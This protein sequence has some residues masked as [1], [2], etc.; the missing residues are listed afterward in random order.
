VPERL[1]Y[2]ISLFQSCGRIALYDDE[3][4]EE[5][6]WVMFFETLGLRAQSYDAQA[7]A[8]SVAEIEAHFAQVRR[9]MLDAVGRLPSHESY[10]R[11][12]TR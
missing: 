8:P 7:N 1:A 2:K 12:M 4:Y 3:I 5:A 11:S 10:L 6:Y 9:V